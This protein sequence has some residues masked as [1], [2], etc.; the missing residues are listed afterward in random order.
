MTI[1]KNNKTW[2][3]FISHASEDKNSFVRPLAAALQ[4]LG[5]SVWYDEFT[6]M[7]GD[8]LSRSI[9]KGLLNS[10]HGLVII[11]HNFISKWWPGYKLRG[12]VAREV[13]EDRVIIPVWLGVTRSD[14]I[15]FSPTL[16]DKIAI[17]TDN[18]NAEE[19]SNQV[20]RVVRPDIYN[21]HS[22][23]ELHNIANR[24]AIGE[25]QCDLE[26]VQEELKETKEQLSEYQCLICGAPLS[27]R[28][29]APADQDENHGDVREIYECGYKCFG[30]HIERLC[31]FDPN[32]P[33]FEDYELRFENN[34]DDSYLKWSCYAWP[35]TDMA[36]Q[37][38]ISVKYGKTKDDAKNSI[39]EKYKEYAHKYDS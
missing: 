36:K 2:D 3:V 4:S 20:L 6:L 27:I 19:V 10:K 22:R 32:F 23:A 1:K 26:L 13:D 35:K 7:P 9:D 14:V 15:S 17:T 39:Y 25:L 38:R 37:L 28:I 31:P 24:Q 18:L 34:T 8:S 21:N 29:H 5:V 12:L 33:A 11:S 16:A 30:G